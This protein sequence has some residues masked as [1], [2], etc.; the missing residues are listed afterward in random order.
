MCLY[1]TKSPF[2]KLLPSLWLY[3]PK[4]AKKDIR[5]YKV[6]GVPSL[7]TPFRLERYTLEERKSVP[8]F[9]LSIGRE[10][11]VT[12]GLHAYTNLED[13]LSYSDLFYRAFRA[14]IPAGS[15]YY[16]NSRGWAIVSLDLIVHNMAWNPK[17]KR[18][19]KFL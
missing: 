7:A 13:A 2:E 12:E 16:I 1:L 5:V 14:T 17:H 15:K 6:L 10:P 9:G 3:R 11:A 18:F 19:E 4:T 8:K